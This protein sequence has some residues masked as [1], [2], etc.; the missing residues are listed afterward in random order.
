MNQSFTRFALRA[1]SSDSG[2][3]CMTVAIYTTGSLGA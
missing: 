2:S 1:R 3:L